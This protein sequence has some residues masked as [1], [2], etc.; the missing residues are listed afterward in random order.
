MVM[1]MAMAVAIDDYLHFLMIMSNNGNKKYHYL[2]HE[3]HC[4]FA[5]RDEEV[6]YR[7]HLHVF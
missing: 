4:R 1:A 6:L 5:G 2:G 3:Q 7:I